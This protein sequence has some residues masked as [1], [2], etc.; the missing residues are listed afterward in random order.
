MAASNIRKT[1]K[2]RT[3]ILKPRSRS[4]LKRAARRRTTDLPSPG[5]ALPNQLPINPPLLQL[6]WSAPPSI[7]RRW[8]RLL[9]T[10]RDLQSLFRILNQ[11]WLAH[12]TAAIHLEVNFVD[13][14]AIRILHRDFLQDS[15]ATDVIT[16]DLGATPAGQR[17]AAIAVCVPVAQ[18]YAERYGVSLRAELQRLV[19]HGVL[20]LLGYDDHTAAG[21]KR[22][23]LVENK[24]LSKLPARILHSIKKAG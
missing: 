3:R 5:A 17:L 12:S 13:E 24:I 16:F 6:Q 11:F 19:I 8:G 15:S 14:K 10:N 2:L 7:R 22:M 9:P 18:N 21:K 20:H 1:R 23:R 4:P